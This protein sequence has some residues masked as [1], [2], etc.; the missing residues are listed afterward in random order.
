MIQNYH[1]NLG[2]IAEAI[3]LAGNN[4]LLISDS[5][6]ARGL[7]PD[8]AASVFMVLLYETGPRVQELIDPTPANIRFSA[9][10]VAKLHGKGN[11]TRLVPVNADTAAIVRNYIR[12]C[13]R[14]AVN[15]SLRHSRAIHQQLLLKFMQ[16]KKFRT[17]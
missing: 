5:S 17:P 15:E 13:K 8:G 7:L 10:V 14:T 12:R 16:S 9:T 1:I 2:V 3:K 6:N 11:K 4:L